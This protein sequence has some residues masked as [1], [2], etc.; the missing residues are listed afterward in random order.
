MTKDQ[1]KAETFEELIAN[2]RARG[3][4]PKGPVREVYGWAADELE[5][6]IKRTRSAP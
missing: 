1:R 4:G 6:L 2:W 3:G 5:E